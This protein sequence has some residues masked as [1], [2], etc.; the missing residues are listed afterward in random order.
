M[1]IAARRVL[2][3]VYPDDD[4]LSKVFV[5]DAVEALSVLSWD[6]PLF[7]DDVIV[8]SP[9]IFVILIVSYGRIPDAGR[10]FLTMEAV[11]ISLKSNHSGTLL[12]EHFTTVLSGIFR[13]V[14][15]LEQVFE[16][17]W[18]RRKDHNFFCTFVE[19]GCRSNCY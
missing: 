9:L 7:G 16:L 12:P 5:E 3:G 6:A 10:V 14:L 18:L 2:V 19:K 4:C 17:Y 8:G 13:T 15:T 1:E 11:K